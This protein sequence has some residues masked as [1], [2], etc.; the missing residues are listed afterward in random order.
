M[1]KLK[2]TQ[3]T[4]QLFA[5]FFWELATGFVNAT[6]DTL[7]IEMRRPLPYNQTH[8]VLSACAGISVDLQRFALGD[9][10]F[11]R[12]SGNFTHGFFGEGGV[13]A[14]GAAFRRV[15]RYATQARLAPGP[16]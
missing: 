16:P 8:V 5:H 3:D 13:L 1:E 10:T 11:A 6:T 4:T 2:N 14:G 15:V 9:S 7:R 12:N